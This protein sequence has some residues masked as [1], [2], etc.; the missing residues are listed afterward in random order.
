MSL[1]KTSGGGISHGKEC[2]LWGGSLLGKGWYTADTTEASKIMENSKRRR[3]AVGRA[4]RE[5]DGKIT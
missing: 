5:I 4:S 1:R 2:H 3:R